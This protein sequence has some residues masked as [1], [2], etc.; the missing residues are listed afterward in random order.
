MGDGVA[1]ILLAAG[2]SRRMG[3]EDKLWADLGGRPVVAHALATFASVEDVGTLAV[4]APAARHAEIRALF[5]RA[6][7][8]SPSALVLV[9]G[10]ARRRDSVGAG[11]AAVP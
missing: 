8:R 11:V 10:G 5:E 1:A 9:E 7:A 3:G 6:R 4:V 2:S